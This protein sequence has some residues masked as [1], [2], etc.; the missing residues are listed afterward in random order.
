[1]QR[2]VNVL[3]LQCKIETHGKLFHSLLQYSFPYVK[4]ILEPFKCVDSEKPR[5]NSV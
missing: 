4:V 2:G 5:L 3:P 1:M